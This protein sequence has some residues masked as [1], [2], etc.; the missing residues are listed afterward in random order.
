M[1]SQNHVFDESTYIRL[2]YY[3]ERLVTP[4]TRSSSLK[5]HTQSTIG[6]FARKRLSTELELVARL[7]HSQFSTAEVTF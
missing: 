4:R 2:I 7:Q 3:V 1:G 6:I 5:L